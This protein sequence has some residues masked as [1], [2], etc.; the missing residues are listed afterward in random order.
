MG[1]TLLDKIRNNRIRQSLDLNHTIIDRINHKRIRLYG[2]IQ[3][4]N[5]TRYPKILMEANVAKKND[6]KEDLPRDGQ[7]A[8]KTAAVHKI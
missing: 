6:P 8:S 4:M 5:S 3:R 2:H 1:V 7:I